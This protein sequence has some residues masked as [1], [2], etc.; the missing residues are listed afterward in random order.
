[1]WNSRGEPWRTLYQID[2]GPGGVRA[3]GSSYA[4]LAQSGKL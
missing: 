4:A 2:D 3:S 1:V